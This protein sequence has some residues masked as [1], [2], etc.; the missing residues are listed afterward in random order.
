[1]SDNKVYV[2]WEERVMRRESGNRLVH[3]YLNDA[4]GN[5]LLAVVGTER[6]LRHMVYS[7][8]EDFIRVFGSTIEVHSGMKWQTKREVVDLLISIASRGDPIIA[9]SNS[10][11]AQPCPEVKITMSDKPP[12]RPEQQSRKLSKF[13]HNIELLSEDSGMRG[14]WFRC[15]VIKSS[16]KLLL[17]Q[18]YDVPDAD[19]SGKLEE[20]VSASKVAAADILGMRFTGRPAIRPWPRENSSDLT[21]KVGA[22]V[23]AWQSNCWCEGIV[24]GFSTSADKNPHVY[25]PGEKRFSAVERK[26]LR[27]SRDWINNKWVDIDGKPDILSWLSSNHSPRVIPP[28]PRFPVSAEAS[29]PSTSSKRPRSAATSVA[30]QYVE[31][32]NYKK[33]LVIRYCEEMAQKGSGSTVHGDTTGEPNEV[34]RK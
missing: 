31:V 4:A 30:P 33:R 8:T 13:N 6:S 12:V 22:A 14:C 1:M 26:N 10:Q 5:S 19:G 2:G 20:R 29:M 11:V 27:V 32:L 16:K 18:Y 23:D 25:F 28:V 15:K 34:A 3:F 9:H 17:V 7:V 21:L 24:F